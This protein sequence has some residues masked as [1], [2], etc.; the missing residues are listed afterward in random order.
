MPTKTSNISRTSGSGMNYVCRYCRKPFIYENRYLAHECIQMKK[1]NELNTPVGQAAQQY[2]HMW[3]RQQKRAVHSDDAFL[4]SKYFRTF[5]FF[6][7]FVKQVNLPKPDKFIWLMVQ[8]KYSPSMWKSEDVYAE[9]IE[10]LDRKV[11]PIDQ[12]LLST[13]TILKYTDREHIDP[14][15]FFL[16]I[17]VPDLIHML[18]T[19]KLSPWLLIYSIRFKEFFINKATAEQQIIINNLIGIDYLDE[20]KKEHADSIEKIKELVKGLGI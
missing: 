19:R 2:Y 18:R 10:F 11:S 4:H 3:M 8:R 13:E 16:N 9:Y 12:V 7:N 20:K 5:I 6:A 17:T 1:I 14:S 15:E